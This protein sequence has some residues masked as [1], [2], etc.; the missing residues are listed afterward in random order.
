[1]AKKPLPQNKPDGEPSPFSLEEVLAP[2]TEREKQAERLAAIAQ[3]Q[4]RTSVKYKQPR[5]DEI[6]KSIDL[7]AGKTKPALKGRWNVPLPIMAGFHDTLLS[8]TDDAPHVKFG[9]TDIADMPR[10]AKV[11]AKFDQ[12]SS[13]VAEMW[14]L[15]DRMEKS[16]AIFCGVGISKVYA[17]NDDEGNY[18]PVYE[19]ID[20]Q[21][22]ECEPMGGQILKDHKFKGQRNI[23]KSKADLMKGAMGDN[24]IYSKRQVLKLI[25]T[26]GSDDYKRFDKIYQEKTERLKALGFAPEM[27]SY[28]GVPTYNLTEWYMEDPE[29]GEK[30][31]L[32]FEAR[33]GVWVRACPLKEVFESN[34]DPFVAWHTH[35]DPF[36]FWSKAPSDDMRPVA[37]AM[38]IIFNQAL[39]NREKKNYGQRAYD[40]AVFPDPSQLEWRPDGLVETESGI[41]Q[42][43]MGGI[44]AGVYNFT[45]QD[46]P[47][48]GTI[49]LM[50][51]MDNF[52]GTKTGVTNDAQG[53]SQEK[54]NGIYF[55]NLQ[56]VADRLGLYNKSYSEAWG[57][58]G[59][60]YYF[61][62]REHIQNNKLMVRMI[63]V[64]GYNW[65]ELVKEDTQPS[66]DFNI[67]IV[68]GQAQAQ[69][70]ELTERRQLDG[71][72]LLLTVPAAAARMNVDVTIEETLRLSKFDE[73]TIKRFMDSQGYGAAEVMAEATQAI[74]DILDG[75]NPKQNRS[76]TPLF[77]QT[78]IDFASDSEDL[79]L[80]TYN[81]LM[82]YAE[83]HQQIALM[84][85]MRKARMQASMQGM[86]L[87]APGGGAPGGG[88]GGGAPVAGN[89]APSPDGETGLTPAAARSAVTG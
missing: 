80:A 89:P 23:F 15:K 24:P 67:T 37:E 87:G 70:D 52:S 88:G 78:I 85:S 73:A 41:S 58:K 56:Q 11:Q 40:P 36:N 27:N 61:G 50:Q 3:Q 49:N 77:M 71:L 21:D 19:V 62:L 82:M 76:A 30:W 51:F 81:K 53:Q 86:M 7:G 45:I 25:A 59:R 10:A 4:L 35:P 17:Y 74:E 83:S 9:H 26:V 66:H 14:A 57:R 22:F 8:K 46:M 2:V 28:M 47:E 60:L 84:N 44:G 55:G 42:A 54:T 6:Q 65:V 18:R 1:M 33:S 38:T 68:G 34:E 29:T 12:D 32:L 39:D 64:D 75:G 63:G 48:A 13:D 16:L 72:K 5:M 43:G 79:D 20:Y 31:Y 69:N